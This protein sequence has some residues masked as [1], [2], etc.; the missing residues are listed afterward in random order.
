MKE[1]RRLL[2]L[3]ARPTASEQVNIAPGCLYPSFADTSENPGGATQPRGSADFGRRDYS[4]LAVDAAACSRHTGKNPPGDGSPGGINKMH[5]HPP[6]DHIIPARST[7]ARS[8]PPYD[9][10][11]RDPRAATPPPQRAWKSTG[12]RKRPA[13]D[14]GTAAN[15]EPSLTGGQQ[16]SGNPHGCLSD[17]LSPSAGPVARTNY[18]GADSRTMIAAL[19]IPIRRQPAGHASTASEI[20]VRGTPLSPAPDIC[21]RVG[22]ETH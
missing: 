21:R 1:S 20:T 16:L 14:N 2:P 17:S 10:I 9:P 3:R 11:R 19:R 15:H 5:D 7:N 12:D 13:I 4:E 8:I 18:H 6:H 22:S